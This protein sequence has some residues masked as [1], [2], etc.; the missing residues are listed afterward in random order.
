MVERTI[1]NYVEELTLFGFLNETNQNCVVKYAKVPDV[2]EEKYAINY[3][4]NVANYAFI[5]A[6]S[7]AKSNIASA[8]QYN[9]I[10]RSKSSECYSS[11]I[12]NKQKMGECIDA[13]VSF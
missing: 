9:G 2:D 6:L 11:F 13:R 12:S 10:L 7:I 8:K 1:S 4:A 3:C 5:G